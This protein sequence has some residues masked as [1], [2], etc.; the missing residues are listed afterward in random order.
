MKYWKHFF[1]LLYRIPNTVV[2]A[3]AANPLHTYLLLLRNAL[4]ESLEF[5]T[6]Y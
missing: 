1:G 2:L 6:R 4:F 3:E 5:R